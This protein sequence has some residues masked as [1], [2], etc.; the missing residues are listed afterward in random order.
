MRYLAHGFDLRIPSSSALAAQ[1]SA[2]PASLGCRPDDSA[3]PKRDRRLTLTRIDKRGRLGKRITEL[4]AI[5]AAALGG[6]LTPMQR[7]KIQRAAELGALAE[8]ARGTYLR[9]EG[10]DLHEVGPGRAQSRPGHLRA[11]GIS[12]AKPTQP[13]LA[14]VLG[15]PKR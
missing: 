15:M 5:F 1:S 4:T 7:L 12:E 13:T 3:A 8:L 9:G 2:T 6:E 14:Q 11:L 10:G